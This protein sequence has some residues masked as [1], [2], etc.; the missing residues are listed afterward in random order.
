MAINS[1]PAPNAVLNRR[2]RARI[3]ADLNEAVY[4][5]GRVMVTDP[6]HAVLHEVINALL[7]E[8]TLCDLTP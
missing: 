8:L 7:D 1:A 4:D 5:A 6:R 3:L 2:S